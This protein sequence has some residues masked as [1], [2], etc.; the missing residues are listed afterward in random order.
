M[1]VS[2]LAALA[3]AEIAGPVSSAIVNKG[4]L[5]GQSSPALMLPL[6]VNLT[7]PRWVKNATSAPTPRRSC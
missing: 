7:T 1:I 5:I 6:K 3:V 2:A 4:N